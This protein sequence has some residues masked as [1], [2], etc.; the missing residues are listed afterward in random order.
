M[1]E[2]SEFV[3]AYFVQTRNEIDTE[4]R[5]RDRILDFIVLILGALAFGIFQSESAQRFLDR[6]EALAIEMPAL[7]IISA[8]FW[9]RWRKLQQ[10]SDRW[11]ALHRIAIRHY[12]EERVKEM[13]EGVVFKDLPS[14]RY[15]SKDFVLNIALC[16]PV[17][18]LLILQAI[19]GHS[20]DQWWRIGLPIGAIVLHVVLSSAVLGRRMRD[21]LPPLSNEQPSSS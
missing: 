12:S 9:I 19:E 8:L 7:A 6:P 18:G 14:W 17:Y 3:R 11:F 13:L 1:S 4:K 2:P 21:P 5:E 20:A 10:I 15:I 16:L